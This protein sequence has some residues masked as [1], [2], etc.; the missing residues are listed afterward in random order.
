M[1]PRTSSEARSSAGV[2][3]AN[4]APAH[5]AEMVDSLS[6]GFM[7]IDKSWRFTY[8]NQTAERYLQQERQ[9]LLGRD[10]WECYPDLVGSGYYRAYQHTALTGDPDSYTG[11]YAPLDT[12]FEA[13][14]FRHDDGI[15]VLFR[16]VTR[17]HRYAAQL[18]YDADH[19]FLTGLAN[20]RKCMETLAHAV[21]APTVPSGPRPWGRRRWTRSPVSAPAASA[22]C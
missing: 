6:D 13:R 9:N 22:P 8:L 7:S 21:T 15:T 1:E 14:S 10:I 16:D 12:W 20:R 3:V 2:C 11:Y 4:A 17:V 5:L 18:Q 19:D